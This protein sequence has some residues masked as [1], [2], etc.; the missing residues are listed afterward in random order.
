MI[1]FDIYFIQLSV[2][3]TFFIKPH[4][5][6]VSTDKY[7]QRLMIQTVRMSDAGEYS[8]VAG[9]SMSKAHLTVEGK[10]VRITEPVE[11]EITVIIYILYNDVLWQD[12]QK[13]G[14]C[15]DY[16]VM[17][18]FFFFLFFRFLRSRE[19]HWNL[20]SMRMTSKDA[21]SEMVLNFKSQLI[22]VTTMWS[23]GKSIAWPS[24]KPSGV[25]LESTLSLLGRTGVWWHYMSTVSAVSLFQHL[26][27]CGLFNH[28]TVSTYCPKLK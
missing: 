5:F 26:I 21:G 22:S 16:Q 25:M 18:N 2:L 24:L 10:D 17:I 8:V 23:L 12:F 20:K 1:L 27:S 19:L 4:R 28:L 13:H 15:H 9:S 7:I 3:I 6:K 14:H 11:K